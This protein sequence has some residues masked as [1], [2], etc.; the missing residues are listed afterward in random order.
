MR[1]ICVLKTIPSFTAIRPTCTHQWLSYYDVQ[2]MLLKDLLCSRK[3]INRTGGSIQEWQLCKSWLRATSLQRD[4]IPSG[5]CTSKVGHDEWWNCPWYHPEPG[6]SLATVMQQHVTLH[7]HIVNAI[8]DPWR[9]QAKIT[10]TS[11]YTCDK[12]LQGRNVLILN[13]RSTSAMWRS[14]W[15]LCNVLSLNKRPDCALSKKIH[16]K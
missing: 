2:C 10:D 7:E 16:N 15:R 1:E 3:D 4:N 6:S 11:P 5:L 9:S 13:L 14:G 8:L 12:L